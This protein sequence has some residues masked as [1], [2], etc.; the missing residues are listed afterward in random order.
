MQKNLCCAALLP[1]LPAALRANYL[2]IAMVV[3][4]VVVAKV[5]QQLNYFNFTN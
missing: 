2:R 1:F 4:L 5:F 3:I